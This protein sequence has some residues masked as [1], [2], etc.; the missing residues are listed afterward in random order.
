MSTDMFP[1][2][3]WDYLIEKQKEGEADDTAN[4]I[5]EALEEAD[6]QE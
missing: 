6:E 3:F 5:V 4:L 1:D 2:G